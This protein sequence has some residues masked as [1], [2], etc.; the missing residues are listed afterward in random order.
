MV[1]VPGL[2]IGPLRDTQQSPAAPLDKASQ[3]AAGQRFH[4]AISRMRWVPSALGSAT[5]IDRALV[6]QGRYGPIRSRTEANP[7]GRRMSAS[8]GCGHAHRGPHWRRMRLILVLAG[9]G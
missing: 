3:L 7:S 5:S 1:R 2:L 8:V 6:K 4:T 9:D